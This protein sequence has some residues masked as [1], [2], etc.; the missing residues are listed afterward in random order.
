MNALNNRR[1]EGYLDVVVL[2]LVAMLTVV[3]I[4]KT[5]PVFIVK[6]QLDSYATQ[7]LR[8]AEIT[9]R[10]GS[11][12]EQRARELTEDFGIA[13]NI[14]WSKTGA[15]QLNEAISVTLTYEVEIGLFAGF[16]SFKVP[17]RAV[18]SG[19]GEVYWK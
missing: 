13:P 7:L 15:I 1:A 4:I 8:E 19:K 12:V 9:G 11:E 3:L 5:L 2:I 6:Q 17:L 14:S 10:V 18:S 16:G